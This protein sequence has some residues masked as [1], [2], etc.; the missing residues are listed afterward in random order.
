MKKYK[1]PIKRSIKTLY[2]KTRESGVNEW[3]CT[4]C[5]LTFDNPSLLNLHTLTHA[6]EN[7]GL[8]D[9]LENEPNTEQN[10]EM[11]GL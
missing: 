3:V 1:E 2:K 6:A 5:S 7:V 9:Q 4:H 8:M 10:G 11:P